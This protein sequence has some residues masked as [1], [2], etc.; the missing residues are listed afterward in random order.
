MVTYVMYEF[1]SVCDWYVAVPKL[2][3]TADIS[4]SE[5]RKSHG[6]A[7]WVKNLISFHFIIIKVV[8]SYVFVPLRWA[9]WV[10]SEGPCRS[11][12]GW[13]HSWPEEPLPT[14]NPR[15]ILQQQEAHFL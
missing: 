14:L 4:Y 13:Q 10:L 2:L 5:R 8:G 11:P 15:S 7:N 9:L 1:M 6:Y 12:G 3:I